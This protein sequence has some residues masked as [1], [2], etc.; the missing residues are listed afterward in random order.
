MK[1]IFFLITLFI[2]FIGALCS[3]A[4]AETE[5][6]KV[7]S[8]NYDDSSSLVYITTINKNEIQQENEP[9][10]YIRLSNPNRIYFDIKNAILIGEKQQLVF[11]KSEI[12]EIRIA[13][14]ETNP[15]IVRAV[16]TFEEDFDTSK[17]KLKSIENGIICQIKNLA[18]TNDYFNSIYEEA[19]YYQ[20]YS[21]I[22]ANSQIIQK[23]SIPQNETI[24]APENVI[25]DIQRAFENSTLNNSNG[26]DYDAIASIDLSSNLKLRTKYFINQYIPKNGGLLVSG[27]G[28]ITTGRM[29]HLTSPNRAVIDLPNAFLDKNVR[30]KEISLCSDK[31][32][33]DTAKIGQFEHNIARIVITSDRAEKY[34]PVYSQDSQSIFLIDSDMLNHTSLV[35]NISNINSNNQNELSK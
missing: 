10:K 4:I 31:T 30:N 22:V 1:K 27:L 28:Q 9:I 6:L 32:C 26:K 35:S 2:F 7:L 12:K 33:N 19:P 29:F 16:I 34:M 17:I 25:D 24:K 13:Q 11:E 3:S 14:F 5:P 23:V 18:I 20:P 15:D 8:L 21:S